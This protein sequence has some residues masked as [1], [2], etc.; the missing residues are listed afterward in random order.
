MRNF[1]LG[2]SIAFLIL[3][4]FSAFPQQKFQY[5]GNWGQAG[6]SVVQQDQSGIIVNFS[7]PDF[8]IDPV[9]VNGKHQSSIQLPGVFLF[10]NEGAPNVP[11]TGRYIA[12][13][14]GAT[15]FVEVLDQR[16]EIIQ[17]VELAPAPRIPKE[18]EDGLEYPVDQSIYS[19]NAYYPAQA[20]LLSAP[21]KVRGVDVVMLGISPFQYNPVTKELLVYKDIKVKVHFLGGNAHFGIDRLRSRWFDP[22]LED[23]LLNPKSL[24]KVDYN[25]TTLNTDEVGYE[26]LII[27]PNDEIFSQWADSI[28]KFRTRQGIITGIKTL[29]EVGGNTTTAIENYINNA[30]NTWSIPPVACLLIGDFGTN[31]ANTL[32]SPIYN[33]YCASDNIYG[34]VDGNSM[35]DVVMARMTAQDG[36]Q[37]QVMVRKFLDYERNP[38]MSPAFYDH[39]ITALGW[40]T[41]RWFQV[42]SEVI[43]G[44]WKNNL[45][46]HPVRVNAVYVGDPSVDP[47][48]SAT[49]TSTVVSYFG[50]SGLGYIPATPQGL[51]GWTGGTPAD[52]NIA[53][54]EGS[55]ML[56]HR[57]HGFENG[58]GEPGYTTPDIDDLTNTDLSYIMSV[59]CLTGKFNYS[60][61]VFAERFHR[62]TYNGQPAGALGVLA[63][64]EVSYSFVND[65]FVWGMY[66]NMWP[67]FLPAYGSNPADR[68]IL[69]AFGN[70]AG[71]YFLQQSGWPY[72]TT[73]KEVTYNLFHHHGD[74]FLTV[75]S[76]VP[77]S[78][79]VV[80]NPTI[81]TA[82]TSFAV[83]ADAGALI[84]LSMNGEILGTG[85][86]TGAPVSITIPG[87]QIPP[88]VIDVVVTKQNRLRYEG[89][90]NVIPPNGPFVVKNVVIVNDTAGNSDGLVD[91][92][93]AIQLTVAVKNV[94][95]SQANNVVVN[96]STSDPFITMGT[97]SANYGNIAASLIVSVTN[98]YSFTVANN[99][100]DGHLIVFKLTAS[101]GTN[102]WV[103]YF[104][105]Q[106]HAPVIS[107][108]SFSVN[109]S[110]GNNNH[111][112][113]P[114]ENFTL[115][116]IIK[117][118]GS[119]KAVNVF[120]LLSTADTVA[121]V[122]AAALPYGDLA[123]GTTG[124]A[125][126]S[127]TADSATPTGHMVLFNLGL[128]AN[129]G[130]TG[131]GSFTTVFGQIPALVI[132][133]DPNHNSGPIIKTSIQSLDLSCDYTT[134]FPTGLDDY[135]SI[136]VC[137]GVYSG[138][139][140]LSFTQGQ[141]LAS[142]LN[143]G[144]RVY[145]EGGE[146][147]FYDVQTPVH[148]MFKITGLADGSGDLATVNGQS[149]SF[150]Q[151]M[152]F[153]YSFSNNYVDRI[154]ILNGSTAFKI[155]QNQ[156]PSYCT[157]IAYDG[158][159]YKTIGVSHEFGGLTGN[160]CPSTKE[161]LMYQYMVFF[162]LRNNDYLKAKF[163]ATNTNVC[164]NTT[165]SFHDKSVSCPDSWY[166]EFPGG[167][168]SSS[169]LSSPVVT[170]DSIGLFDVKLIVTKGA[171]VDSILKP[172][173]IKVITLP[174]Q[175]NQPTG[176]ISVCNNVPLCSYSTSP[177]AEVTAYAWN[178]T[179]SS[180]GTLNSTDTTVNANW[181][182]V[183]SGLA[184]ISVSAVNQCG[185]GAAS[186]PIEVLVKLPPVVTQTNFD[187]VCSSWGPVQLSGGLP[188]G[189]TYT[190][191]AVSSGWFWPASAIPGNNNLMYTYLDANYCIASVTKPIF[192]DPC[193]GIDNPAVNPVSFELFPNPV[194]HVLH[195]KVNG[196]KA[197][198]SRVTVSNLVGENLYDSKITT[199]TS[200]L[201]LDLNAEAWS[202]GI[203][204]I[205]LKSDK[206]FFCRKFVV[207]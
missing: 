192:V 9:I 26:Y 2:F 147:W 83:T 165:A 76:E 56:Q 194:S 178:M 103:S 156:I 99:I 50:P 92:G 40:Q 159:N 114:G 64:T 113:D 29:A 46:K 34:D 169:S 36:P 197:S 42:C 61:E 184:S 186:V 135:K 11:G 127:V 45:G 39:P 117:N 30:Y 173:I 65:V 126:Y 75:F 170:Y 48:S 119:S 153:S 164:L 91:Y 7:V 151:G 79:T 179:P 134:I 154:G 104:S 166:W 193:I 150:T 187:N 105:L 133:L 188:I 189:G 86:G 16:I 124:L 200:E 94:G 148:P 25:K 149:G 12:I 14:E 3:L 47:W 85:I 67:E 142:F 158:G 120:G 131:S 37:L 130:I 136:F 181:S 78:L 8:S 10:N 199:S 27:V 176:P 80:H 122:N 5:E 21:T 140:A 77:Q 161:N 174:V 69:P 98:A 207:E 52:V 206:D 90:V 97:A 101:D 185:S 6:F 71:K 58:W 111:R 43:G 41:E 73:N 168:P 177:I 201:N 205:T 23:M 204:F 88:D 87:N 66:D 145:M 123:P 89:V 110:L 84:C 180:A 146:T 196:M 54:N 93:E 160:N 109:D 49:N 44:F 163:S 195:L 28:K 74:A 144:G 35:P 19:N 143:A 38:P 22:L 182:N 62:Y 63:A 190:G 20:T 53:L 155:F 13:P 24:Q 116:I 17:N 125:S 203:Y 95:N 175:A 70:A 106:G 157:G 72:N 129:L 137:L 82:E 100:P 121:L 33:S 162:G 138:V 1:Y 141:A 81:Y 96:L 51:S 102:N 107:Y 112:I 118:S 183:F 132:D 172:G 198:Q 57:D 171:L 31:A 68:G 139:T 18:N 152:S 202:K 4:S 55:F 60:S 128:N 32:I 59:N 167:N 15:A 115:D 191:N 108:V